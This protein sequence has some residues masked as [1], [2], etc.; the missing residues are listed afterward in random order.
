M[1]FYRKQPRGCWEIPIQYNESVILYYIFFVIAR[2]V[3]VVI[4]GRRSREYPALNLRFLANPITFTV[5]MATI[6]ILLH[7]FR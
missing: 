7:I 2:I 6:L 1:V 5:A 4:P 3:D